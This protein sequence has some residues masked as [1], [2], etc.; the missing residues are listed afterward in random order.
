LAGFY[1]FENSDLHALLS[2]NELLVRIRLAFQKLYLLPVFDQFR[3]LFAAEPL[4]CGMWFHSHFDSVMTQFI[5]DKR[6]DA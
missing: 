5:F 4:A 3:G 2:A 1:Q 6:T